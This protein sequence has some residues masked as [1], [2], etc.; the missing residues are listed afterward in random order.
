MVSWDDKSISTRAFT[1]RVEPVIIG[2]TENEDGFTLFVEIIKRYED[3]IEITTE[4]ADA[5]NEAA[6]AAEDAADSAK[7]CC[8]RHPGGGAAW[9]LRRRG[10]FQ[11]DGR[12]HA[13]RGGCTITITDKNGTTTAPTS[14]RA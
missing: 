11:P 1:I 9:R 12:R 3:A 5:A 13:D 7:R 4:A 8:G 6:E 2:G 10:R 14:P